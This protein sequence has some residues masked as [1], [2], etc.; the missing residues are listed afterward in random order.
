ME[1]KYPVWKNLI[2]GGNRYLMIPVIVS[3][4]FA[5]FSPVLSRSLSIEVTGVFVIVWLGFYFFR[6]LKKELKTVMDFIKLG[7]VLLFSFAI[8]DASYF[9]LANEALL[10]VTPTL[11]MFIYYLDRIVLK[12]MKPLSIVLNILLLLVSIFFIVFANIQTKLA[13]EQAFMADELAREAVRLKKQAEMEAANA[14]EAQ[15]EAEL[16]LSE[17]QNCQEGK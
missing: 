9:K 16:L 4:L 6:F 10:V 1:E 15:Y 2:H 13:Q 12:I 5:F 3:F 8:L 11:L 7:M 14:L 17:L